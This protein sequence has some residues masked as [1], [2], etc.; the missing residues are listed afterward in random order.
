MAEPI[1]EKAIDGATADTIGDQTRTKHHSSWTLFLWA[2]NFD[3]TEHSFTVGLQVSPDGTNW[4]PLRRE[5]GTAVTIN[6]DDLSGGGLLAGDAETYMATVGDVAMP[7]VRAVLTNY[8]TGAGATFY[9]HAWLGGTDNAEGIAGP[10]PAQ[11]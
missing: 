10:H 6:Q 5:D 3:S 8:G 2:D 4:S 11:G 1:H 7:Y 9:V